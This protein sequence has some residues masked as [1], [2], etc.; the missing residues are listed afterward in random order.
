VLTRPARLTI[1]TDSAY[2]KDGITRWLAGWIRRG[3]KTAGGKP[4]KNAELWQRLSAAAARHEVSWEWVR[5]H[6]GEDGNERADGL[7]R[8]GMK[9]FLP[10]N[11]GADPG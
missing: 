10:Q 6:A 5:G 7:A 9:P 4:V 11:A 8:Q 1:F 2:V 3:W